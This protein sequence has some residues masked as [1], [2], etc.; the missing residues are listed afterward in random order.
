[1]KRREFIT[2][3][4]GATAWPLAARAQQPALPV[5]GFLHAVS[6]VPFARLVAEF[7]RG[8]NESG[9]TVGQN[10]MIEFR[11][12][13]G[14]FDRLP[15]LAADLVHRRVNVIATPG[16]TSAALA[17]KAA[18]ATIPIVFGIPDDP[19]KFGLVATLAR[20]GGNVTGINFLTAELITK[21]ARPAA[22]ARA[23]GRACRGVDQPEQYDQC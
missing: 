3:V 7:R 2:L 1:M 11:W 12:A 4:G 20:P 19:V 10:V 23:Q 15:D 9:Y 13:E 5:I 21:E 6:P 16:Y 14:R 17:A 8:L 18:T 22:R